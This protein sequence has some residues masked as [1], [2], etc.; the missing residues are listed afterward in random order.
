MNPACEPIYGN[1]EIG[2][3]GDSVSFVSDGLRVDRFTVLNVFFLGDAF[4]ITVFMRLDMSY[5]VLGSS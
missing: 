4:H 3:I 1:R 2:E 5:E